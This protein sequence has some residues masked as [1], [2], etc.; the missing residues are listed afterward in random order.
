MTADRTHL[1]APY[2]PPKEDC[3]ISYGPPS[4]DC[5]ASPRPMTSQ[6]HGLTLPV[7]TTSYAPTAASVNEP[8]RASFALTQTSARPAGDRRSKRARR[9]LT[10]EMAENRRRTL[11]SKIA[12]VARQLRE[13]VLYHDL[14]RMPLRDLAALLEDLEAQRAA[15]IT[16]EQGCRIT[17]LS[18]RLGITPAS[19][20]SRVRELFGVDSSANLTSEQADRYLEDLERLAGRESAALQTARE[21]A[22]ER[23]LVVFSVGDPVFDGH[24]IRRIA[25]VRRCPQAPR[26]VV[27]ALEF[28]ELD[29]LVHEPV[30]TVRYSG[31]AWV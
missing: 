2:D 1:T 23:E 6:A 20:Y 22:I 8:V 31:A 13:I 21:S 4:E 11:I 10:P 7:A 26:G 17:V 24:Q 27:Y 15:R 28:D 19:E 14:Q 29:P 5:A 25:A 3:A 18:A 9:P 30:G 12:P 16:P